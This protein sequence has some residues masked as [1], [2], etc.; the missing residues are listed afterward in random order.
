MYGSLEEKI[1][2][3]NIGAVLPHKFMETMS[4][5]DSAF[6]Q[7]APEKL[8]GSGIKATEFGSLLQSPNLLKKTSNFIPRKADE[9]SEL[10]ITNV[11]VQDIKPLSEE[12]TK[13]GKKKL[14]NMKTGQEK[15]GLG[16]DG[17][18]GLIDGQGKDILNWEG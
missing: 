10:D 3:L 12:S 16:K 17:Q 18:D 1:R 2:S 11:T 8:N 13:K 14:K 6:R 5:L 4:S 9:R 7:F 15:V